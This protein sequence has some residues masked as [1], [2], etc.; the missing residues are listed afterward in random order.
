VIEGLTLTGGAIDENGGAIYME[1][2]SPTIRSCIIRDNAT[3]GTVADGG[4]I[5][6]RY[7]SPDIID[8]MISGNTAADKG[9]GIHCHGS[10]PHIKRSIFV[11]NTSTTFG[12]GLFCWSYSF[13]TV[14]SCTFYGNSGVEAGGIAVGNNSRPTIVKSIISFSTVGRGVFCDGTSDALIVCS[15]VYG[16]EGGDW[17]SCIA[18]WDSMDGNF[19]EDPLFCDPAS[20]DFRLEAG[21]PCLDAPDCGQVGAL[22]DTCDVS[23]LRTDQEEIRPFG[24]LGSRPNPSGRS[25]ELVFS[26]PRPEI[27]RLTVHDATGRTVA[28]LRERHYGPGTHQ[29]RWDGLDSSGHEV[30]PGTYFCRLKAGDQ[31]AVEKIVLVR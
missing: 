20:L 26:L 13:P 4:A 17:V 11:D 7:S 28:V 23:A 9:G 5:G 31:V 18:V 15:D 19:H 10:S 8:C 25:T 24:L 29:V 16:N 6:C 21:S 30:A 27:I 3:T 22:G 12:G 1:Y 14:D 2:S